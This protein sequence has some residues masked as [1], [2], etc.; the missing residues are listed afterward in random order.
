MIALAT[1]FGAAALAAGSC[2][3]LA[4][5]S[6]T[7]QV[8]WVSPIGQRV[9]PAAWVEVVRVKDLRGWLQASDKTQVRTLQALGM[10]PRSGGKSAESQYKITLFDVRSDWLC[11]PI[12][13]AVPGEMHGGM[14][15]CEERQQKGLGPARKGF[16][17]CGYSLDTG[18]STRALDVYR[19]QWDVAA[20]WGFCTMPLE[21]FLGGA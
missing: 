14:P 12:E 17:G 5:P 21:R 2:E 8:A 6:E 9:G 4:P 10:V 1:L 3:D 13:G 7:M 18:A 20:T 11:R 16:T 15:V 19:V